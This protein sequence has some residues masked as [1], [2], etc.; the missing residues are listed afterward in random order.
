MDRPCEWEVK[1]RARH[2]ADVTF[3][4]GGDQGEGTA[5]TL[6]WYDSGKFYAYCRMEGHHR[7]RCNRMSGPGRKPAAGRPL[8]FMYWWLQQAA[9]HA[10]QEG[11]QLDRWPSWAE[12]KAARQELK[13]LQGSA[14]LMFKAADKMNGPDVWRR[15]VRLMGKGLANRHIELE[16]EPKIGRA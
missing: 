15:V 16:R 14:L 2:A 5:H 13:A 11:H 1:F 12:R 10:N 9:R 7:C 8:G 4:L 3:H 6:V